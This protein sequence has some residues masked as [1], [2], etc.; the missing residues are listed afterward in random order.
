MTREKYKVLVAGDEGSRG[1]VVSL[2]EDEADLI[3][4]VADEI[5]TQDDAP[6]GLRLHIE[7]VD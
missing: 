6:Y 7:K 1:A 4:F 5:D 3:R 2:S